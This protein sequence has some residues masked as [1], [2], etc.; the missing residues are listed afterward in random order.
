MTFLVGSTMQGGWAIAET[1]QVGLVLDKKLGWN[2]YGNKD[3]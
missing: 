1:G 3:A 2:V